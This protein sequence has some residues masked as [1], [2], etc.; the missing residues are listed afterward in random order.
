MA[1]L[2]SHTRSIVAMLDASPAEQLTINGSYAVETFEDGFWRQTD[3]VQIFVDTD[4][5]APV[6]VV[7]APAAG[8]RHKLLGL[9]VEQPN[10]AD[11]T[12][13]F[14]ILVSGVYKRL[15]RFTLSEGD[16]LGFA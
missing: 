15:K 4:G 1:L 13:R 6:T 10:A 8:K 7:P 12:I 11:V 5:T 9:D 2:D 16:N 14:K 3:K